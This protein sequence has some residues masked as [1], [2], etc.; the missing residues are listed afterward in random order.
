MTVNEA[1]GTTV[2]PLNSKT[3]IPQVGLGV[4]QTKPHECTA[5]VLEALKAGYRHIDTAALYANEA[6]VG[7]A[8][9]QSGIPRSDI[10]VTTKLWND[11]HGYESTLKAIDVSLKKLGLSYVDLYLIH[12]P[13]G[14]SRLDSWRAF[15]KIYKDGKAK[16][17]GVSNYG[18]HHLEEL[19]KH[20]TI[21][22]AVNQIELHPYLQ[23]REIVEYCRQKGIVVEAYCPLTRGKKLDDPRLLAIAKRHNKT[24]AQVLVR[25][26]IDKGY[27]TLPKS[28]NFQRLRDNADVFDFSLTKEDLEAMDKFEEDLHLSWDP[29]VWA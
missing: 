1:L 10:F 9:R 3:A 4:W 20:S 7:E 14:E 23:Q 13:V 6:E 15:E 18:V 16:A 19:A 2:V 28:A 11:D 29:T 22:P 5:V 17:I 26:G 24:A 25:W 21:T 27:V 12:A 8:I